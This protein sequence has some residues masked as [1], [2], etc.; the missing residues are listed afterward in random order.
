LCTYP[1]DIAN[2]DAALG[3]RADADSNPDDLMAND[4]GVWCLALW[5][6]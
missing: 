2:L 4:N 1:D 6:R 5:C 3:L